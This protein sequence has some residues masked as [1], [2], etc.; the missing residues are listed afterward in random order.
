M[1][2]EGVETQE[3]A[4][5]LRAQGVQYAQGWLFGKPMS[6][7]QFGILAIER[8]NAEVFFPTRRS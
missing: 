2:A 4:D 3:Q 6:A 8:S 5:C 1:I 7:R